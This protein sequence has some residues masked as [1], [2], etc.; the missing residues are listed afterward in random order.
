MKV[1]EQVESAAF[2]QI[3]PGV[4]VQTREYTQ[5]V[6]YVCTHAVASAHA[7]HMHYTWVWAYQDAS[8]V[9]VPWGGSLPA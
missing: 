1:V 6:K 9:F 8:P 2:S 7:V 4:R 5:S 3:V